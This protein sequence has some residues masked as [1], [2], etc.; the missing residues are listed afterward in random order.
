MAKALFIYDSPDKNADL[1]YAC[2][3]RA[4]RA[5]VFFELK[6]KKHMVLGDLEFDRCKLESKIE[7]VLSLSRYTALAVKKNKSPT[8][9]DILDEILKGHG[10]DE[11]VVHATTPFML[12]DNLRKR[13]YKIKSGP[14]PFYPERFIK[15]Q[16]ERK[17]IT[18]VQRSIFAAIDM[19]KG[20]LKASKIKGNRLVYKS[21]TLTSERLRTMINIF[22]LEREALSNDT[23][24]AGGEDAV[25]PHAAGS[26]PLRAH[27]S[28]VIDIFPYSTKNFYF[29]DATRTFCKGH[30]PEA[31]KKMYAT[32]NEGQKIGLKMVCDGANGR[33][34]HRAITDYFD[35]M[36]YHTGEKNGR[37]QG[38]IHGTG[39]SIGLEAHEEPL[40]I[41]LRNCILNAGNVMSVEP[42]LYYEGIGGVRIE[43]LV[44]VTKTGCEV[45]SGYPKKLEII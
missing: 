20:V 24:V 29:G 7:H 33:T 41:G 43:D 5:A 9:E 17:Y 10:I 15:T 32:V 34:I 44:Y 11:L 42:G 19:A 14:I 16:L 45:L 1:Y 36:G 35:K 21:E 27:Q 12:V 37:F 30:A 2:G 6:G 22:L 23:I 38:F 40:R 25:N 8:Q 4:F 28:I 26:G 39:H 31:L 3:F 18:N 13:G